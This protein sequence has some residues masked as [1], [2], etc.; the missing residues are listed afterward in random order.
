MK[1]ADE[2][3]AA[4]FHIAK[5]DL[6]VVGHL[7]DEVGDVVQLGAERRARRGVHQDDQLERA[8]GTLGRSQIRDAGGFAVNLQ[9][10]VLGL[11]AEGGSL[12]IFW[13]QGDD[14]LAM[15]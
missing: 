7:L 6:C 9:L 8:A 10:K 13:Q 4:V 1:R 3:S 12:F 15:A 5:D 11:D 2:S 14:G